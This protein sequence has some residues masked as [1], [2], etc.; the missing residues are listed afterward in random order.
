MERR[1]KRT[2]RL[3]GLVPGHED[4]GRASQQE[5]ALGGGEAE[6]EQAR[7]GRKLAEP[8]TKLAERDV[9]CSIDMA[10][11]PLVALANVEEVIRG[12]LLA[13]VLGSHTSI[14]RER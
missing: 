7:A 1:R 11:V 13:E 3:A 4:L 9:L 8:I 14:L 2:E 6:R 12:P 5:P 10:G